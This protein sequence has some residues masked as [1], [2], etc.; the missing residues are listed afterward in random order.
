MARKFFPLTKWS[1]RLVILLVCVLA[2]GASGLKLQQDAKAKMKQAM[3]AFNSADYDRAIELF[4][5]IVH[6]RNLHKDDRR[7][8]LWNLGRVYVAKNLQDNAKEA[9]AELLELEPP[10]VEPD[11]DLEPPPL[12]KIYYEVRKTKSGSY[13]VERADPGIKTIAILDFSNRSIDDRERLN[14]LEKGF[15]E[16]LINRLTGVVNL[17]VVERERIQWILDEIGL[18]NEP[19][20]FDVNSA[21]R[22]GKQLGV[23]TVLLGS[24]INAKNDL[25]LGAR[26][27]K[28]ETSEIL[29]TEDMKGKTDKFFELTR[30]LGEKIA[31]KIDVA[32]SEALLEAGTETKSLEA[33]LAYSE[34]LGYLENGEYTKA[35][36]KFEA[37]LKYDPSY[38]KARKK[39]DSIKGVVG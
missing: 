1:K 18:E 28:V 21:V 24:F 23:H 27:V 14:P 15:S 25:W 20:K 26:L 8:V 12:M 3:T 35:Y 38:Q 32:V 33:M 13:A 6:D 2:L 34:G 31:K 9:I 7:I 4:A 29:M 16:L 36:K 19:G 11:P 30:K 17:K 10:L 39:M 37:A 22:V 5:S